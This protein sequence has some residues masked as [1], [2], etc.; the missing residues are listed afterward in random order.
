MS[1][2]KKILL[3]DDEVDLCSMLQKSIERIGYHCDFCYSVNQAK[4]KLLKFKYDAVLTD[5]NIAGESGLEL[6][7]YVVDTFPKTPIAVISAY[8]DSDV[9]IKALKLGAFDFLSKPVDQVNLKQVLE[10][11][12]DQSSK[13]DET[14]VDQDHL[15]LNT[16]I[17][18]SS[19]LREMK[20]RLVKISKGQAPIFIQGES[21]SGKEVVAGV[22]HKLSG[23]SK[24]PFVAI[25]CGA[26]PQDLMESELFGHKKGS[27]TGATTDKIGLIHSADGGTLFL[28][29][30][31]ELPLSMQVKILRALQEKKIRPVGSDKE[32]SVDFRLVSAT[33]QNMENLIQKGKFRHD[34]Y[35]RVHVMDVYV[36][37]LRERDVDIILLAE[38]FCKKICKEWNLPVKK[39]SPEVNS[40]LLSYNFPGNV[41]ELHNTIQK[42]ITLSENE[43]IVLKDLDV[44]ASNRSIQISLN[45]NAGKVQDGD[46]SIVVNLNQPI[47]ETLVETLHN[48]LP[49]NLKNV[50]PLMVG[51]QVA[52]PEEG[53]EAHLKNYE[54]RMIEEALRRAVGRHVEAAKLLDMPIR[55]FRYRLE[56]LG[57][58]SASFK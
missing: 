28:D 24:G 47:E 56:C 48:A 40:W 58:D 13:E 45:V 51:G 35:F 15:I 57:I 27:F 52:L 10:K 17:G 49:D 22:I 46:P 9:S 2:L 42:A 38:H 36:P 26:I 30:I 23:R 14:T 7:S 55:S 54:K 25:N 34:L 18:E 53:I 21:G 6:V 20:K 5:M 44:Q 8:G 19:V 4:T 37:P 29:E 39:I 43:S 31:A 12:M 1:E 16:L 50:I 11:A 33:H 41:R 3:V 32:I